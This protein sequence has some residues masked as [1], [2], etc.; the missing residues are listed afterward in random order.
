MLL[1]VLPKTDAF[2]TLVAAGCGGSGFVFRPGNLIASK[3]QL[4]QAMRAAAEAYQKK[5]KRL[6]QLSTLNNHVKT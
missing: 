4:I 3:A 1:A 2:H 6:H 5:N